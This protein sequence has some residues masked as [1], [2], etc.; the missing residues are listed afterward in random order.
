MRAGYHKVFPGGVQ[1]PCR[2]AGERAAPAWC[3]ALA[4]LPRTGAPDKVYAAAGAGFCAGETAA[5][6]FAVVAVS[7]WSRL[8]AGLRVGVL[9]LDGPGLPGAAASGSS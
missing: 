4:G 2:T 1:A 7:G 8:A 6:A 9:T 5:L 3:G